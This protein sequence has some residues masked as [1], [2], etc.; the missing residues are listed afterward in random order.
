MGPVFQLLA[1]GILLGDSDY[2]VPALGHYRLQRSGILGRAEGGAAAGSRPR[3]GPIPVQ[4]AYQSWPVGPQRRLSPAPGAG[5]PPPGHGRPTRF[6][7][8]VS[9]RTSVLNHNLCGR[10]VAG[11]C[12]QQNQPFGGIRHL[13]HDLHP[14]E[15]S[16][17]CSATPI[18]TS[19]AGL[20]LGVAS[21]VLGSGSFWHS[22]DSAS[23]TLTKV[24]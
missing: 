21:V 17:R 3:N 2:E 5:W 14:G 6:I 20:E 8:H 1:P 9:F 13:P 7:G 19:T 4:T 16:F 15:Q 22:P 24:A 18:P 23:L 12:S 10:F 11:P